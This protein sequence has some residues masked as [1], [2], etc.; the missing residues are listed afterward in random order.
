MPVFRRSKFLISLASLPV[1]CFIAGSLLAQVD[2]VT[3]VSPVF[4]SLP[5]IEE[6]TLPVPPRQLPALGISSDKPVIIT[7]PYVGQST[8]ADRGQANPSVPQAKSE[9]LQV[10]NVTSNLKNWRQAFD[11]PTLDLSQIEPQPLL[12][13]PLATLAEPPSPPVGTSIRVAQAANLGPKQIPSVPK[14]N[15][16][17][18]LQCRLMVRP[19][20]I[21]YRNRWS[22]TSSL[23]FWFDSS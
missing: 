3:D 14:S 9:T 15:Q 22:V 8:Q 11:G 23:I 6:S 4:E 1:S 12:A 13:P 2:A 18:I 7:N 5:N 16:R 17:M 19:T 20:R 10:P 21:K